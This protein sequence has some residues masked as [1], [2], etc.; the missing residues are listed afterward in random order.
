M[1]HLA[2]RRIHHTRPRGPS[3]DEHAARSDQGSA[4]PPYLT[5]LTGPS[6]RS[7]P[8]RAPRCSLSTPI[9][10]RRA[11]L[12]V[13][14]DALPNLVREQLLAGIPWSGRDDDEVGGLVRAL[15]EAG[16]QAPAV[17]HAVVACLG[18][19]DALLRARAVDLLLRIGPAAPAEPIAHAMREHQALLDGHHH[20]ERAPHRADLYDDLLTALTASATE[21]DLAAIET[22][23]R[24]AA[25]GRPGAL[26]LARLRP[27]LLLHDPSLLPRSALGGALLKLRDPDDRVTL[28]LL[29]A[30][31]PDADTLLPPPYWRWFGAQGEP[32]RALVEAHRQAAPPR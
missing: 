22:L 27:K 30:P 15:A 1:S 19:N 16:A 13:P 31:F 17:L 24:G 4:R 29:F 6:T 8:R 20:P 18:D 21:H 25:A 5:T 23:H 10:L 26:G 12:P 3:T 28:L 2:T 7:T 32:L 14:D 11:G 9:G